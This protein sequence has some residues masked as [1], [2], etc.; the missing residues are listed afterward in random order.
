VNGAATGV[1][2][3][4]RYKRVLCKGINSAQS[5]KTLKDVE[6]LVS[7]RVCV[8]DCVIWFINSNAK[9]LPLSNK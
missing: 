3:A 7:R 5:L 1:Y 6:K 4:T 9:H 8:S 2:V